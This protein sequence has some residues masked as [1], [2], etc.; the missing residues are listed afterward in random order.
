MKLCER[1]HLTR[2]TEID[3]SHL[4]DNTWREGGQGPGQIL[5]TE[6][7][8]DEKGH[9][10]HRTFE[11]DHQVSLMLHSHPTPGHHHRIL[12]IENRMLAKDIIMIILS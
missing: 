1:Y 10:N 6:T 12:S 7:L 11:H 9:H 3:R 4:H 2:V 5:Q 8:E